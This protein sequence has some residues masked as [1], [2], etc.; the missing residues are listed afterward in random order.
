MCRPC[1][2]ARAAAVCQLAD[3]AAAARWGSDRAQPA[4]LVSRSP[5]VFPRPSPILILSTGKHRLL[6]SVLRQL[7]VATDDSEGTAFLRVDLHPLLVPD[8]PTALMAIASQ[9]RVAHA[10]MTMRGS[11]C[12]GLR[13]LL[14]LLRRARPG[15]DGESAVEG[16]SH[17]VLFVLH[18][19]ERFTLRPKQTLLYSLYDLMQ[20]EDAAM[21]VVGLTT[22]I[23]ISDLLEKRVRSR[24]SQ[25]QLLVPP[26][27]SADD[28]SRVLSVA[29]ALP[30]L[31]GFGPVFAA[32]AR[33]YHHAWGA[34]T[35]A[36][37]AS[38]ATEA[39]Q[40]TR[41]L[42][43]GITA[44][45]LQTALRLV[46]SELKDEPDDRGGFGGPVLTV[47][48]LEKAL[49]TLV[50]PRPETILVECSY[51]ELLLLLCLKKLIDK[52][53]PPPHTFRMVL[54]EYGGFLMAD[55]ES[56]SQFDYPRDLLTKSF[57]HLFALGLI[58]HVEPRPKSLAN[59]QLPLRLAV[60][61]QVI[62]NYVKDLKVC[63][64]P[65][66]RFGTTVTL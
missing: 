19:F 23:D 40:L 29:L 5:S 21:A 8:E 49:R 16:Q 12:D 20:T 53:M 54:K 11:F 56:T 2:L 44:G 36:V 27:T 34:N 6:S 65:I 1:S 32:K 64:L 45:Q 39:P 18:D 15:T 59:D 47:A 3:P 42:S 43:M 61:P 31:E 48:A 33:A 38:L 10:E 13:H 58:A 14:H 52:E 22:R 50:L 9:L 46:L 66:R 30:T 60:D 41:G 35:V 7:P 51:V 17:P 4:P 62:L 57:E 24:C 26:L 63:A 25:R 55:V 28:C 37:C